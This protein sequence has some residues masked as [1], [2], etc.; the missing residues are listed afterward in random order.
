MTLT[1][2]IVQTMNPL[3]S[4][5]IPIFNRADTI[6]RAI[7]GCLGQTYEN[8]EIVL[9]DDCSTDD[10]DAALKGFIDDQRVRLVRHDVNQ[11]VSAARNTGV[12]QAKG[13]LVAFLDSDD[14]WYPTKLEKQIAALLALDD[15][16]PFVCGTLTEVVSDEAPTKVIPARRKPNETPFGD[17]MFVHK[18][19]RNL[20]LVADSRAARADGYFVHLSSVVLP[21]QLAVETPLRTSLNQY[22]DLAFVIDL[23]QKGARFALIEEPLTIQHDDQRA[24]RLGKRD[25]VERGYRFMEKM[26]KGLSDDARLAFETSHLGHLLVS[27]RPLYV[28]RIVASAFRRGLISPRSVLGILFRSLFGQGPHRIVRDAITSL[29]FGRGAAVGR[30]P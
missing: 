29:R 9:V 16:K 8:V 18:V 11:G 21:R 10:L 28:I 20:P 12:R 30:H 26:G 23:E 15:G 5:V 27:D 17:Y 14:A 1:E 22:E 25:D 3:I 6:G 13:D 19:R 24:G 2:P 4:I 7:E